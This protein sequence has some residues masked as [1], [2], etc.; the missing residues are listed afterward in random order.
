MSST[1]TVMLKTMMAALRTFVFV[2]LFFMLTLVYATFIIIYGLFRPES[3]VYGRI[4]K[5]WSR[6]FLRIPPVTVESSGQEHADAD[7]RYVVVSNHLSTFDIPLLFHVLPVDGRYL[8]KKELFRIPVVGTAMRR[9]GII[10]VDREAGRSSRAAINDGVRLAA[11][12]GY[13]LIVFPEG[14]RSDTDELLPFKKGA[15]RIAIDT[16]L[17][18]L[19]VVIEGT[20][21]ISKPGSKLFH[22]GRARV[23]ILPPVETADLTNRDDL[24][25][26]MNTVEASITQSYQELRAAH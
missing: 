16:G 3:R 20:D 17:P 15:F 1:L 12:R 6:T 24:T 21:R 8:S 25:D 2:P 14:T 13:S 4:L 10:E 23:R 11:E 22:P 5:R 19:P 7:A 9:I 18:I 26:L